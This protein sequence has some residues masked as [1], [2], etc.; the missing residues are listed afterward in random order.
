MSET[1]EQRAGGALANLQLGDH[2]ICLY[3]SGVD[4]L[5]VI[6]GLV[7]QAVSRH[8]K[9]LCVVDESDQD[10]LLRLI[11]QKNIPA[12]SLVKTGQISFLFPDATARKNEGT[13]PQALLTFFETAAYRA[14]A[15]GFSGLCALSVMDSFIPSLGD[16]QRLVTFEA[17]Q[18]TAVFSKKSLLICLYSKKSAR[19]A[20]LLEIIKTHHWIIMGGTVHENPFHLPPGVFLSVSRAEA[21]FA[22]AVGTLTATHSGS[23]LPNPPAKPAPPPAAYTPAPRLPS[24]PELAEFP[25]ASP[26]SPSKGTENTAPL[27]RDKTVRL[28]EMLNAGH[29]LLARGQQEKA[30]LEAVCRLLVEKGGYRMA[31]AGW[32]ERGPA[33]RVRPVAQC[34]FEA[35]FLFTLHVSWSAAD[36]A[37]GPTGA[38]IRSGKP[39]VIRQI[40]THPTGFPWREQAARRGYGAVASL[41]L[42]AGES[43]LGALTLYSADP[44]SFDAAEMD[45][46]QPLSEHLGLRL[47]ELRSRAEQSLQERQLLLP[48]ALLQAQPLPMACL[49][50]AGRLLYV[51]PAFLA[52]WECERDE[53]LLGQPLTALADHPEQAADLLRQA[54]MNGK[55][56]GHLEARLKNGTLRPLQFEAAVIRDEMGNPVRLMASLGRNAEKS[57]Q[58]KWETLE[59]ERNEWT[60]KVEK[61][62]AELQSARD[63]A[64]AAGRTKNDFL[65][66]ISH[67]LRTPLNAVIGFS[68][69]L[70]EPSFGSLTSKQTEYVNH[71]LESGTHL[72]GL[73]DD[74]LTIS[75]VETGSLVLQP[76]PVALY[77]L[78]NECVGHFGPNCENQGL[79]LRLIVEDSARDLVVQADAAKLK[80]IVSNLLANAVKFTS[81]GGQILATLRALPN[82]EA[83]VN[84]PAFPSPYALPHI[85]QRQPAIA[86]PG[87]EITVSDSGIGVDPSFHDSIFAEF[88]QIRNSPHRKPAGTGLG[89]AL[90]RRFVNMHGGQIWV[91]S[92][93]CDKGSRFVCVLPFDIKP[94]TQE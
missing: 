29:A 45:Y 14:Q 88:F 74:I 58:E 49:D 18:N 78:L 83:A 23:E 3:D 59:R 4:K 41:P 42:S 60:G 79:S 90:T 69:V 17:M 44:D 68:E 32:A 75:K 31:W 21:E 89:L 72:Q 33:R 48:E 82:A 36:P 80:Q 73:I 66:G 93:G 92:E 47:Q 8:Q 6:A 65:A 39:S 35:D 53:E 85:L 55:V 64:E 26:P 5:H 16:G 91:E 56:F 57:L 84:A 54:L 34:G 77:P 10:E 81:E 71:I 2:A 27:S 9:T 19:P 67:E 61:M 87:V 52:V 12:H 63:A 46:L 76:G 1:T 50:T 28:L 62:A 7:E 86:F 24:F 43:I 94:S 11:E 51:N 13:D 40:P 70:L 37:G 15:Q 25:A 22:H 38:A 20:L 30:L